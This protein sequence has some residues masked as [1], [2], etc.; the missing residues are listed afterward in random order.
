MEL[1]GI[2][3]N[4][5]FSFTWIIENFSY[6]WHKNGECIQSSAFVVDTMANT[7]WRLKLYPKGQ[8]ETEVEFFSF[9]LNREADCKGLKKLEIFFEISLLAADG[10]VLESKGER[11]EFEKGDGW[12]LYE[13]V[14]NDEVF[15]IRR[16]DYLSEDV[17]TAHCRM[18]K[19]IKAVKIDG[20]CFARIRIVVER[21]SFLWNIKQFS[22]F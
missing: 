6:S 19:S 7:K 9:V 3:E 5:W 22:S 21:R 15:K 12:C 13:F 11:G 18:R 14:E 20:Y 4:K 17:Q 1:E 10:V 8:A 2:S 16:K